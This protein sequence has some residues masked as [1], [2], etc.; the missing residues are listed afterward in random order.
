MG[1][2]ST[3]LGTRPPGVPRLRTLDG[4]AQ[5]DDDDVESLLERASDA[6][7]RGDG[8][9][10][11]RLAEAALSLEPENSD[12]RAI[13]TFARFRERK[14][15]R[16][17]NA[18]ARRRLSVL[19]CDVVSSTELASRLDPE[20]TRE[21]L[22]EYQ[23]V[24]AAVIE[25]FDG[26]V[27]HFIGDGILAYFGFPTAHEDDAARAALAGRAMVEAVDRLRFH[28]A[29]AGLSIRVGVHTGLVVVADMGGGRKTESHDIVGET[30]N[31]AARIQAQ[32]VAGQV[33]ISDSTYAL[34]NIAVETEFRRDASLKGI[35]RPVALY[36]VV[37]ERTVPWRFASTGASTNHLVDRKVERDAIT[38]LW[39]QAS[40]HGAA[41][42][43]SGEAGVGKSRIVRFATELA[44][45]DRS[46][47]L[48][49]QCSSLHSN[50]SLWPVARELRRMISFDGRTPT[51]RDVTA[52]T[53]LEGSGD[54]EAILSVMSTEA[55]PH[56][57]PSAASP[58]QLREQRFE[59]L[60]RWLDSL[61]ADQ[62]TMI[63][64]E[65][66]H[67]ADPTTVE[68]LRQLVDRPAIQPMLVILTSRTAPP[69]AAT[70]LTALSIGP[71]SAADCSEL[72]DQ[73]VPE[74]SGR[75]ELRTA[76]IARGDGVPLYIEELAKMALENGFDTITSAGDDHVPIALHDLLVARLDQ[77]SAQRDVAQALATFGQPVAAAM[78]A[79]VLEETEAKV[80]RDLETLVAGSLVRR[81][82]ERYEFVHQLLRDAAERLQ[83]R[84]RRRLL[85]GRIAE[86]LS[87]AESDHDDFDQVVAH[88]HERADQFG[89]AARRYLRAAVRQA[90]IAAHNEAILS[91]TRA[92]EQADRDPEGVPADFA[93]EVASGKAASLLASRG[94]TAPEVGEAYEAVRSLAAPNQSRQHLVAVCG[95]WAYHHVRGDNRA[96][97]PLAEVLLDL[98]QLSE[99]PGDLLAGEAVLG[100]QRVWCGET[101]TSLPL[102]RNAL[103]REASLG[104]DPLPHDP[105]SGA[106]VNLALG[107][108]L[109]GDHQAAAAMTDESIRRVEALTIP[110]AAFTSAYVFAFAAQVRNLLGDHIGAIDLAQR[111]MGVSSQYGFAS[112]LGVGWVQFAIAT[113]GLDPTDEA[114]GGLYEGRRLWIAS[115]AGS[116]MSHVLLALGES[117]EKRRRFD[118]G[119]AIT[120]EAIEHVE[121]NDERFVE[122]LIRILH[123]RLL[124]GSGQLGDESYSTFR[125]AVD[126]ARVQG[127]Q[128]LEA[129]A[130]EALLEYGA[131]EGSAVLADRSG[132]ST[133]LAEL[134][135]VSYPPI[136][137]GERT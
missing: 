100:Y 125:S 63:V 87:A 10:A 127:A 55:S 56:A 97:A 66:L 29:D 129:L 83:L 79:S 5:T 24:C 126:A 115:G 51:A 42:W 136:D 93:I 59:V 75:E 40:T 17:D 95:L 103:R 133:R 121:R 28:G 85:H 81:T 135:S 21:I 73:I 110:G 31:L 64:I 27:A 106:A 19:F 120:T 41:L 108:W 124:V 11:M 39:Q 132:L 107:L 65:D 2:D 37:G 4:A 113:A 6:L 74:G 8:E 1:A 22:R 13:I 18:A 98:A 72:I 52:G 34:A 25:S 104:T 44:D 86:A 23:A 76:V 92:A 123:G 134:R 68:L 116:G 114:I 111:A 53:G 77:Y 99:Q 101:A 119:L 67:W 102:L 26:T 12:A 45:R 47:L 118:E 131:T 30:P 90:S 9:A 7:G 78:I 137:G 117:L 62:R 32:A 82:E 94:Y 109:V 88:H 105:A 16:A 122:V 70:A 38:T 20:D 130:I 96:S 91:F 69:F 89:Q 48:V 57:A 71:L 60:I 54:I 14:K 84:R 61:A 112:W 33:L 36:E 80:R 3:G 35:S 15:P 46:R 50:D 58:Q 128:A 49:F 43:L